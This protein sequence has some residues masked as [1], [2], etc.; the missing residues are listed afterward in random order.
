MI[1][2]PPA[3]YSAEGN[4][5]LINIVL[6]GSKKIISVGV[7]EVRIKD[8]LKIKDTLEPIF[9]ISEIKPLPLPTSH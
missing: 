7:L 6:K 2:N 1:T 3:R 4:S 8:R 9:L 5:G